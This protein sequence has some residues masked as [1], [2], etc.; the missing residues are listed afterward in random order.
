M[1]VI[2]QFSGGKDSHASLI[3]AVNKYG[4]SNVKALFCDTEW[5]HHFTTKHIETV[6]AQLGVELIVLKS[7]GFQGLALKKGFFPSARFRFCTDHLKIRPFI[8]WVLEQNSNLIIVQGI[9]AAES[10]RRA[11]MAAECRYFRFY[12]EP[13]GHDRNGKPKNH[14]Y[15][16]KEVREWCSRF[17]D[18][19]FRPVFNW[20]GQEVIDYIVKNGH[21]PNPLYTLGFKR[22]GCFP[23]VLSSLP[24]IFNLFQR[25]PEQLELIS[26]METKLQA[27]FFKFDSVPLELRTGRVEGK[28]GIK[29]STALD[30]FNYMQGQNATLDMFEDNTPSCSSYYHLC[31]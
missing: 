3:W 28:P 19:I 8:D 20:T 31:E 29:Y 27:P 16:A 9:R 23:C 7:L 25:F 6:C 10:S 11:A 24:A 17:A 18:D 13:Y 22:V 12:F 5:E 21:E 30:I 26:Q 1:Q 4:P 15:R 14:T 2:V